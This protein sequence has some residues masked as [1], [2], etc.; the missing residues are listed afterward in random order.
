MKPR[1]AVLQFP[2]INSEYETRRALW[3]AG[4]DADFFRWNDEAQK[5]NDYDGF[6]IAG[7][8]SY[9]DRGRAG[10]VASMEPVID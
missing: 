4:I 2:G 8:F 7:G 3:D 9:E 10:L 6:V 1:V 5:L